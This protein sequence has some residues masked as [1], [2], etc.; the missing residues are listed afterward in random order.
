MIVITLAAGMGT[1]MGNL[2]IDKPKIM[3]EF[4]GETLLSRQKQIF[5]EKKIKHYLVSGYRSTTIDFPS[6]SMK[7]N[8]EFSRTNMVYSLWCARDFIKEHNNED[9]I[10]SYGDIIYQRNVVESL[11]RETKGNIQLCADKSF[12]AL[13]TARMDNPLDDLES[14]QID[15]MTGYISNIGKKTDNLTEIEAQYIGLFKINASFIF[16]FYELYESLLMKSNA[17]KRLAMTDFL[18]LLIN[19]GADINPVYIQGGWLEFD[20]EQDLEKYNL[21]VKTGELRNFYAD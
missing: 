17:Y 19:A 6:K 7:V 4:L 20:T 21:M 8:E 1:R 15:K 12:L 11:M 18:Q 14:F 10:V 2:C 13:W 3:I 5:L 16:K 9:I